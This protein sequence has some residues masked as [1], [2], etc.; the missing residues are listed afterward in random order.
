MPH[1]RP[2]PKKKGKENEVVMLPFLFF[3]FTIVLLPLACH[4]VSDASVVGPEEEEIVHRKGL[5]LIYDRLWLLGPV[6]T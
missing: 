1:L 5:A 4:R 6:H 2:P 3:Y